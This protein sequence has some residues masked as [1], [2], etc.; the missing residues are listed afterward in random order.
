MD[1]LQTL[2]IQ[3]ACLDLI[4]R[5]A[6]AVNAQDTAGFVGCF[7]EDA[8][9]KRPG[10][11]MHGRAEMARFFDRPDLPKN[12]VHVN[13]TAIV[14][15]IDADNATGHSF[16]TVYNGHGPHDQVAPMQG[17]DYIVEYR[18]RYRRVGDK[19][20]I[21]RR[22]TNIRFRSIHAIPLPGIPEVKLPQS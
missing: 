1:R 18:D 22:D 17:P 11:E 2:E 10:S 9:W 13:G 19:W 14:D 16:T 3:M 6:I 15:V 4:N 12:V 8:V 7:M 21:A 20:Q 5:Y